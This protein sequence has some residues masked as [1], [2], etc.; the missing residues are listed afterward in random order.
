MIYLGLTGWVAMVKVRLPRVEWSPVELASRLSR[1]GIRFNFAS[2]SPDPG[3]VPL[4]RI[5]E[6]VEH[7]LSEYGTGALAYPGAGG[8]KG[9]RVEVAR[10]L[11]DYLG[12]SADWRDVVI[13]SGAQHAIKLLA[14]L[15]VRRGVRVYVEDPTFYET[16]APFRFQGGRVVGIRVT[17]NGM[18]IGQ[19]AKAVDE[20]GVVYTIPSC[21]NPTGVSMSEESRR[22]LVKLAEERELVVVEDDPYTILS[23]NV[24]RPLRALSSSVIYVGTFS[25]LLG[26]G[27]RVGFVVAPGWLRGSLERLEQHDFSTSTLTQL[28]V[29]ELLRMGVISEVLDKARST[30][31]SKLSRLIEALNNYMPGSL[32]FNPSCGFYALVRLGVNAERLLRTAVKFGLTYVPASRFFI[33]KGPVDSA[34]LSIGVIKAEDIE[35]GVKLLSRLVKDQY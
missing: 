15:L 26:P 22:E 27:F 31:K 16:L 14:Q 30:Y 11:R 24:L 4:S 18:D 21:H 9:L 28:V 23:S 3:L 25:K 2:G 17:N 13:S 5:R 10:Y 34:R 20:G 29:Y 7:V 19:L 6:A 8:F 32:Q 12:V 33:G 35:D 1:R